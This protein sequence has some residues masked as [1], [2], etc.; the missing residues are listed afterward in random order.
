MKLENKVN[1]ELT[2]AEVD[3]IEAF[4]NL[5]NK[6]TDNIIEDVL[7]TFNDC[8]YEYTFDELYDLFDTVDTF[9]RSRLWS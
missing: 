7:Y 1:V 5:F 9:R 4:Y 8:D 2:E 6:I 3:T